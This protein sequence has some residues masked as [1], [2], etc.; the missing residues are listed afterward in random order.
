MV[1]TMGRLAD[2]VLARLAPTAEADA[3]CTYEW[4]TCYCKGGLRYR[5][6]CMYGCS[7][8][9]NHCYSCTVTG[10]C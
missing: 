10:T 6:K 9:P 5:R 3:G 2:R 8:V 4:E 7:G 1:Q